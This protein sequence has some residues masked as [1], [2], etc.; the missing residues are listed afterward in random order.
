[1][2]IDPFGRNIEYLRLSVTDRCDFRCFYCIPKGYKDFSQSDSWLTLDEVERLVRVFSEMGISK[3][4]LTGGEPLVRK[5]LPEMVRRIGALPQIED[6]SLSTNASQLAKHAASLKQSGVSRINVSLDSLN[7]DSFREITQGDLG[8]VLDGL[9]AAK[10]VGLNPIKINMV[11]MK[12]INDHEIGEMVDFCLEHNFTLRF[13]ETMPVG[14]TGMSA[15]DR[16]ISLKEI[17]ADL[18][19]R[20][21]LEPAVM[22]GAGPASYVRVK[23]TNLR[24]GFITP[25]SQHFC[26]SCNRVRISVEGTLYLCLG[27]HDYAE[28][29][30]LMRQ[31]ISDEGLKEVIL[32]A[33]AR[34]PARHEFNEN[35]GEVVRVMSLTGG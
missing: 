30:P 18:E 10:E 14:E 21:Q 6:L 23:E 3:V 8:S 32:E 4:R 25:M 13:I 11:V 9:M 33:I 2:L 28:L 20:F 12:G 16:F 1:M 7:P 15:T 17:K 35:P 5:E 34:K 22:R 29:R 19:E 26:E 31:G 27:K 24:I